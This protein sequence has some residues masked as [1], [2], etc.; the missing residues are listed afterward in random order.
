MIIFKVSKKYMI[1]AGID[2]LNFSE[3]YFGFSAEEGIFRK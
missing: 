1:N 3:G 2:N